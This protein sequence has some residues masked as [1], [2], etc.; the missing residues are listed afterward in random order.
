MLS[1]VR[2]RP[3]QPPV[4]NTEI[5]A[6]CTVVRPYAVFLEYCTE[7]AVPPDM[8]QLHS[9]IVEQ[10]ITE[11]DLETLIG[12]QLSPPA[13]ESDDVLT[14]SEQCSKLQTAVLSS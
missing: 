13:H 8:D 9:W 14:F 11:N 4:Q 1:K 6:T 10:L 3:Q 5:V 7:H 2:V 12:I